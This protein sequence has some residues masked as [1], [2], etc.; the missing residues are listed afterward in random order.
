MTV[1]MMA[2]YT[3]SLTPPTRS[4]FLLGP[5]AVGK[6]TW[7]KKHYAAGLMVNLLRA[8]TRLAL[9]RDPSLLQKRVRARPH[10]S[11]VVIDE[12][13]LLPALLSEGHDL[14]E[15][16]G[17]RFA[18]SGS[19]ARKIKRGDANLLAG[20]AIMR[21]MFPLTYEELGHTADLTQRIERGSL[22]LVVNAEEDWDDVLQAYTLTYLREEIQ[23]EAL[24]RNLGAFSRFLE[25]TA[26]AN[27]QITNIS[28]LARDAGVQR[29]TVQGYFQILQDTL[30]GTLLPAWRAR[31]RVKEQQHPKFYW[32]DSGVARAMAGRLRVPIEPEERGHLLETYILHELRSYLHYRKIPGSLSYWR[33]PSGTEVDFIWS[34]AGPEVGI[35]VKASRRWRKEHGNGLR[36]LAESRT[37][38]GLFGVYL[39]EDV[40]QDGN[41]QILPLR[42]FLDRLYSGDLLQI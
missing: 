40:L 3:R 31:V 18:L 17:Y 22:P 2:M 4:F 16:G 11:W 9:L 27:G 41:I 36:A 28:A 20:R 8:D 6:S 32:F 37:L 30:L 25:C 34:G 35:E 15:A 19:S 14:M 7:L 12:V 29:P 26:L 42:Q 23:A 38:Q 5:R 24:V 21:A 13:Q 1:K 10:G 39:G 33:T